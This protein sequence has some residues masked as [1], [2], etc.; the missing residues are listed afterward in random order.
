MPPHCLSN[1]LRKALSVEGESLRSVKW[2]F[3]QILSKE[4]VHCSWGLQHV[5]SNTGRALPG[6]RV[7]GEHHNC[8]Y[9][10]EEESQLE[11][12]LQ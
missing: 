8:C 1:A 5:D 10:Q 6:C 2:G 9:S 3:L 12:K 7:V 11:A 4:Q